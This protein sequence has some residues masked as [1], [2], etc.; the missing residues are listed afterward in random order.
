MV[1]PVGYD[2]APDEGAQLA[3]EELFS[4]AGEFHSMIEIL[5]KPNTAT[6]QKR[7]RE[8]AMTEA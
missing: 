5:V 6:R 2:I 7:E 3:Q 8:I 4:E 1:A